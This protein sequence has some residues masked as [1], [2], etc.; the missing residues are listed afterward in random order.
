MIQTD[1]KECH[2]WARLCGPI[3]AEEGK[4]PMDM[5]KSDVQCEISHGHVAEKK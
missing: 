5:C 4:L 1:V 3:S 2:T